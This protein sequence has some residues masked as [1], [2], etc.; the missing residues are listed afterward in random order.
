MPEITV[1]TT[2]SCPRCVRLKKLL[3]ENNIAYKEADM[4][5]PESLTEL[6]INGVFTNEAP[7]LQIDN[8]FLEGNDLFSGNEVN[9]KALGDLL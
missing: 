4:S 1:Y 7:V 9:K 8:T 6:R 2:Q 3:D 5:T